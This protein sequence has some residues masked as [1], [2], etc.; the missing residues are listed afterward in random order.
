MHIETRKTC[1][2]CGHPLGYPVVSLGPQ[3]IQGAFPKLGAEM[4]P[5]RRVAMDL[6]RCQP[7]V[8]EGACGLVQTKNTIPPEILY[9]SYWYKSGI[10]QTMLE[11]LD[12]IAVEAIGLRSSDWLPSYGNS[13]ALDIGCNDMTLLNLMPESWSKTGVD[14]SSVALE[15]SWKSPQIN[16]Y[17]NTFPSPLRELD[18][19]SFDVITSVAMFYDVNDPVGFAKEVRRVMAKNA[20]WIIEV[21][22]LPAT[23][24]SNSFDTICHEHISYFS[25]ATIENVMKRANLKVFMA[26]LNDSN[27]GSIRCHICRDDSTWALINKSGPELQKIRQREF[28]LNLDSPQPYHDF[29]ARILLIRDRLKKLITDIKSEGKTVHVYG[30]STKGNTLLQF[31]DI[32]ARHCEMAADRNPEK[33][34]AYT[35]GTNIMICSEAESRA[36]NPDYYLVLPWHF[37]KEILARELAAGTS[38]QMIFPLPEVEVVSLKAT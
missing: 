20:V 10:N 22:Y 9:S 16:F 27:G 38:A 32:T 5:N 8:Y 18:D 31:C 37:R 12:E 35:V 28:E 3:H 25:L 11:H 33:N 21:A 26:S 24:A 15:A 17:H 30:A 2:V 23:L 1:R 34:Q 6:M 36:R 7:D 4:P 14:P 29:Q 19:E 13:R